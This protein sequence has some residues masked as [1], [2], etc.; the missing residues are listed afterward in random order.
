MDFL[1]SEFDEWA[2]RYDAEEFHKPHSELTDRE[3]LLGDEITHEVVTRI[4]RRLI[5]EEQ[6]AH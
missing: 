2:A 4:F 5:E 6:D 3:R 1:P